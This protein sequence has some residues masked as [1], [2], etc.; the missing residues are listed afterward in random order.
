MGAQLGAVEFN[1]TQ[2][3]STAHTEPPLCLPPHSELTRAD[4]TLP[5]GACDTHAHVVSPDTTQF[6][7]VC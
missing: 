1:G 3:M 2:T 6:H 4:Y 5:V 7:T